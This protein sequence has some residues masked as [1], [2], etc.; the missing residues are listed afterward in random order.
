MKKYTIFCFVLLLASTAA[1]AQQFALG[2]QLGKT[3]TTFTNAENA[4][5]NTSYKAG[6]KGSYLNIKSN[7]GVETGIL[8]KETGVKDSKG[9]LLAIDNSGLRYDANTSIQPVYF[10]TPLYVFRN[11]PLSPKIDFKVKCGLY[12]ALGFGGKGL[13]SSYYEV[14]VGQYVPFSIFQDS[15]YNPL[16]SPGGIVK[17]ANKPDY[18]LLFGLGFN[19]YG[20][21]L[22]AN[23]DCGL[24]NVYEVYPFNDQSRNIRNRS[25]WVGLGYFFQIK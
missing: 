3:S 5:A 4:V 20:F 19:L 25:F 10:E 7:W 16:Y 14:N 13:L 2:A 1:Y 24:A 21:E 17:S 9:Y 8:I 18:G 6:I 15:E 11:F 22:T 23:Y 12:F